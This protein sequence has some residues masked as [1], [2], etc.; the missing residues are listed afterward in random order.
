MF[1]LMNPRDMLD[2]FAPGSGKPL[3]PGETIVNEGEFV[4]G[5]CVMASGVAEVVVHDTVQA[6]LQEGDFVGEMSFI[7]GSAASADV[8]AKT[9]VEPL[10]QRPNLERFQMKHPHVRDVL[11]AV[12]GREMEKNCAAPTMSTNTC[13]SHLARSSD[14]TDRARHRA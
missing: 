1:D 10:R 5:L 7:A 2:L 13:R 8:R 3:A 9:E 6:T 14:S 4:D 12:L 11:Q